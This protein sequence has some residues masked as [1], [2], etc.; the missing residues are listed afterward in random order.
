MI[1][2][3]LILKVGMKRHNI[4]ATIYDRKGRVL[5]RATNNYT[6]THPLQA[7][8][9]RLAGENERIYLH[10]EIAAL[11]KAG[12]KTPHSIFIERRTKDGPH[13]AG[14]PACAAPCAICRLALEHFGV[15]K[16]TYT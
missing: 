2:R 11:L 6:K 15:K 9:A 5:S 3:L 10:A 14:K 7:Y 12:T 13:G 4:V 8:F 1:W 16:V